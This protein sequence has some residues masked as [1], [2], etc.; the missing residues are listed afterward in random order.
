MCERIQ[1]EDWEV[2]LL[3]SELKANEVRLGYEFYFTG[4]LTTKSLFAP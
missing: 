3:L 2:A 1:R 4:A